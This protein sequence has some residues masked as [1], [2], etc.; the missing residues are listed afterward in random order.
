MVLNN[1]NGKDI[2]YL[3]K[4]FDGFRSSLIEYAK[5]YFPNTHSDFNEASPGMMFIEMASY[6]GDVLSYYIDDT[7]KE[8]MMI[9]AEDRTN[10]VDLAKFLGYVPKTTSPSVVELTVYQL[11]PSIG[12]GESNKPDSDYYLR[13]QEGLSTES[14][15]G[16]I[17]FRTIEELDF[18]D[19]TDRVISVHEISNLTNEP[20]FYLIQKTVTAISASVKSVT[21]SFGESKSY[22]E[23]ILPED[24]VI[25]IYNVI[26]SSGTRW[27]E[28]PYLAQET[29]FTD[30]PI[31]ETNDPLLEKYRDQ[32]PNILKLLKT[33]NR[34]VVNVD[35]DDVTKLVFG[36]GGST[37]DELL[38][39]NLKNV[40]LGIN[41]SIDKMGQSYD[42]SNFL[43]TKTLGKSPANTELT[44]SYLVGGGIDSN[45]PSG[46][47][48]RIRSIEFNGDP[49]SFTEEELDVYNF[50]KSTVALE[51]LGPATG[52]LGNE[53]TNSIRENA[54]ANFASQ[55]RAVTASD[56][57][58]RVLSMP[59][60]FGGVAKV[61]CA[62]FGGDDNRSHAV[63]LYLLAYDVNGKLTKLNDVIKQNVKT[64]I[65]EYRMLTDGVNIQDGYVVNLGIDFEIRTYSGFNNREVLVKCV[66]KLTEYFDVDNWSFNMPVNIS[67]VEVLIASVDGVS[68]VPNVK[69]I[70]KCNG[71]YSKHSYDV[72]AATKSKMIYPPL[73]PSIFEV[74]YPSQDIR[75]RVI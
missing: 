63:N 17:E 72:D 33:S 10:V 21:A 14:E 18:S 58:I 27:H 45:V 69:F 7:L 73:D 20:I 22:S 1:K 71:N 32:V 47:I 68:N 25:S 40:G 9:H 56:Y 61:F 35:G 29:V 5:N 23:I 67:E 74:K 57:Q 41:S 54:L 70:N 30:V 38:I 50:V 6:I 46:S 75:G 11:V 52:G 66:S 3:N 8:S 31:S 28:V 55:N 43:K 12:I 64:H 59:A 13:I 15:S 26:D 65:S 62:P 48:T 16:D 4:D 39:P 51:N 60:K 49:S 44:V 34:F 19:P 37:D 53:S 2:S 24:N 36:G 42:P